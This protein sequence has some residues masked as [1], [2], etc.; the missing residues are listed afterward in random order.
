[1]D[2]EVV[3]G[4]QQHPVGDIGVPVVAEPL[5][6]VVHLAVRDRP[7]TV[8]PDTSPVP[9]GDRLL[10]F[11]GE[12][13]LGSPEVEGL[14]FVTE[15]DGEDAGVA[16]GPLHRLDGDRFGLP[17]NEAIPGPGP[18]VLL[19]DQH[20]HLGP[21]DRKDVFVDGRTGFDDGDEGVESDLLRGPLIPR[22]LL[23]RGL[24]IGVDEPDTAAG[25]DRGVVH[26]GDGGGGF[27]VEE[28]GDSGH[29]IGEEFHVE[30]PLVPERGLAGG[31]TFRVE[32]VAVL[33]CPHPQLLHRQRRRQAEQIG[34]RVGELL[35]RHTLGRLP[36]PGADG[37]RRL[38][39]EASGLDCGRDVAEPD[40]S[41]VVR[42]RC[43]EGGDHRA[44]LHQR[45]RVPVADPGDGLYEF[46]RVR[47]P[48][49]CRESVVPELRSRTMREIRRGHRRARI[50]PTGDLGQILRPLQRPRLTPPTRDRWSE[51]CRQIHQG[52]ERVGDRGHVPILPNPTTRLPAIWIS[53]G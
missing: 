16:D 39:G 7:I 51:G 5:P 23:G 25:C 19:R 4:T 1:V 12:E 45:D 44:D 41:G 15:Q 35:H 17:L 24:P 34:R 49:P 20:L 40:R 28:T 3:E 27:G 29:P 32:V 38:D 11:R 48:E 2:P 47:H 53:G 18:V 21:T 6:D 43:V 33:T 10:L 22:H 52:G 42:A 14:S 50:H 8:R 30:V 26:R 31:D 9:C 13:S 37:L 36:Q 46:G